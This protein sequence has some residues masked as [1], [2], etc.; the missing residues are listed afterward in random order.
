MFFTE[1]I[2]LWLSLLS[3]FSDTLIF[4]FLEGFKPVY[5]Q[6]GFGTIQ[7]GPAF[8]PTLIGYFLA[9][10]SYMPSII[11]FRR[12]RKQNLGSV[13]PEARLWWLLFLAP[14]EFL[15]MMGF[16]WTSLGPDYGIP[17][18]APM[19]F[20]VLV[21]IAN[22]STCCIRPRYHFLTSLVRYLPISN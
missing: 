3:G 16:A 19:L 21:A 15:G 11:R 12:K 4:T 9:Y 20:T 8:I 2:V 1:P 7:L 14:L 6:W 22:V 17:W 18:F 13:A 10:I 5:E